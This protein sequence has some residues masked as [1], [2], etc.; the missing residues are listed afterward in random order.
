AFVDDLTGASTRAY[1]LAAVQHE[2][3]RAHRLEEPLVL[4]FVDVDGLKD[5]NDRDGHAAG[6]AVLRTV[7]AVLREHVRPYDPVVRVGG[8][9]FVCVLSNTTLEAAAVHFAEIGT[10][11]GRDAGT[12]SISSG[13]VALHPGELLDELMARADAE[14]YRSKRARPTDG[15]GGRTVA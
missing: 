1:G 3:H 4:A 9:E 11:L 13:A 7:G 8:D 15:P 5:V 10:A 6:D 12:C 14:L 2:L